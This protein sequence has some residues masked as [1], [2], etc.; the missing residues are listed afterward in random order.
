M[1]IQT[2]YYLS[3]GGEG[4]T[5]THTY[6]YSPL[7]SRAQTDIRLRARFYLA[8]PGM[9]PIQT[10]TNDYLLEIWLMTA[11]TADTHTHA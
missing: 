5:D 10:Q 2:H 7:L 6:T 3:T 1:H 8:L 11:L 4:M 9:L